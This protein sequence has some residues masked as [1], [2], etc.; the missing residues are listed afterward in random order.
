MAARIEH[1]RVEGVETKRCSRCKKYKPLVAFPKDRST[2]D[3]LYVYCKECQVGVNHDTY[4]RRAPE[5]IAYVRRWQ[6]AH[7]ER[8]NAICLD[9]SHRRR[10]SLAASSGEFSVAEFETLCIAVGD[11]CMS[12]GRQIR[13]AADHVVPLSRGG[14]NNIGNIQPLCR[15]CNSK[16][17]TQT[18]DYRVGF[19]AT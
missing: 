11:R 1:R 9:Y 15:Q 14:S 19:E 16:K 4:E 3:G 7:P 10:A 12:C 5:D 2:W 6:A 17:G 18:I 13:L 8:R